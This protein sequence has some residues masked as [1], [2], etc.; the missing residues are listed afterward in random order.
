MHARTYRFSVRS[1]AVSTSAQVSSSAR[2]RQIN[3]QTDREV[4]GKKK[5]RKERKVKAPVVSRTCPSTGRIAR[6]AAVP[7]WLE[8]TVTRVA[9]PFVRLLGWHTQVKTQKHT[10]QQH[11]SREKHTLAHTHTLRLLPV[12]WCSACGARASLIPAAA[13]PL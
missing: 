1:E 9:F 13:A 8:T 3:P 11:L 6:A 10:Q 5:M 4:G 12:C 2:G 7:C